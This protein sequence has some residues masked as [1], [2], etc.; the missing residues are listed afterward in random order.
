MNDMCVCVCVCVHV[1]DVLFPFSLFRREISRAIPERFGQ[2]RQTCVQRQE[3]VVCGGVPLGQ[4][5]SGAAV[6]A[7][8]L[9]LNPKP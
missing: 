7:L 5:R 8:T 6:R 9:T 4:A 2:P 1:R 3:D